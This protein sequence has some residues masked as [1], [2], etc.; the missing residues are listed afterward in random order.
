MVLPHPLGPSRIA[1][2][3]SVTSR[4][5]PLIGRTVSSPLAYSTTRSLI[6]RSA[7]SGS[8]HL[9]VRRT[10]APGRP[11]R[12]VA[13]RPGWLASTPMVM[14]TTGS[15]M[16]AACGM[17]TR[18]GN[19]GPSR[20]ESTPPSRAASTATMTARMDNPPRMDRVGTPTA[21]NTAKSRVRSSADM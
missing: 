14:A 6:R 5:K 9:R 21:L 1:S 20:I 2:E 8:S 7:M 3:P 13:T 11:R 17:S 15:S 12:R 10:P 19:S 18:I 16:K 4:F